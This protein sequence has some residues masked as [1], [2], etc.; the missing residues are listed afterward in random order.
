ENFVAPKTLQ[1]TGRKTPLNVTDLETGKDGAMYFTTGGRGTQSGLY[2]VTYTGTESTSSPA[3]V[4]LAAAS[5]RSLRKQLAAFHGHRDAR[6]V[7][8]A[9]PSLNSDDRWIRYAA[10][11]AIESQPIEEWRQRALDETK[12]NASLTA[13]LALA[14]LGGHDAQQPVIDSLGRLKDLDLTEAQK[15]EGLRVLEVLFARTGK[16]EADAT[17]DIIDALSPA[18][19]TESEP[20]NREISQLLI[21]LEAPGIVEKVMKRVAEAPTQEEQL[22]YIT[23]LRHVKTGWTMD[24]RRAYFGWFNQSR[25]RLAH[26]DDTMKWFADAGRDYSDGASLGNFLKHLRSD[27]VATLTDNEKGELALVILGKTP[28]PAP[29]AE[30]RKFVHEW[31]GDELTPALDQVSRGRSF[32]KGR[33]AFIDAQCMACH[34]FGNEGGAVG[35][36]LT[37]VASRFSRAD[38]L[39]SILEPSKVVSEQ[40]QNTILT[41]KDGDDVIGRVVDENDLRV[42][43]VTNPLTGDKAEVSKAQIAKRVPSKVSPMPEGLVNVLSKEEVLDLLAYLESA[44]KESAAAFK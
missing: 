18:F 12:V 32:T 1:S 34:R 40:Y 41:K 27:A 16:P 24:L 29:V 19:P 11:L 5:A 10:R 33:R 22:F 23:A 4:D 39:S 3:P 31:K 17:G 43:V 9:W 35:P 7:E 28:A 42:V 15:L 44:G 8:V 30:P 2:R 36:D 21:Y 20:L 6:A 13:L 37:A 26:T 25:A 38:I 14:R